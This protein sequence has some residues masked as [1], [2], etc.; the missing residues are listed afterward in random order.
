MTSRRKSASPAPV[1]KPEKVLG[2]GQA[3]QMSLFSDVCDLSPADVAKRLRVVWNGMQQRC[4]NPN[5]A[6]FVRYGG[7][8]IVRDPRFGQFRWFKRWALQNGWQIGLQIDRIDNDGPYSPDN[9]RFVSRSEN[10][11]NTCRTLRF[12]DGRSAPLVAVGNGVAPCVLRRRLR[13]G[14]SLDHAVTVPVRAGQRRPKP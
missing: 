10:Q 9:C 12:C 5:K 14:W 3:V 2:N 6:G 7:R 11:M 1:A 13:D 8:G 4:E